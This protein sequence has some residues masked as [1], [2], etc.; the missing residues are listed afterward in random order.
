VI[1]ITEDGRVARPIN[2]QNKT[3]ALSIELTAIL[4][5]VDHYQFVGRTISVLKC[6]GPIDVDRADG[7]LVGGARAQRQK[8]ENY[9]ARHGSIVPLVVLTCIG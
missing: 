2:N 6:S 7:E 3:S 5:S 9:R 8:R 4:D 1:S